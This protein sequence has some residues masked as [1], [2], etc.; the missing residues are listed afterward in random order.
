MQTCGFVNARWNRATRKLTLCYEL[1][2]D[3]PNSIA[4][5]AA[6]SGRIDERASRG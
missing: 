1:A 3:S 6:P 5:T 4:P 2:Q